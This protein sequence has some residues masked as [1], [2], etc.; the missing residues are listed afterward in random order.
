MNFFRKVGILCILMTS[1]G[2]L[3]LSLN[4]SAQVF[5]VEQIN[6]INCRQIP[7][8]GNIHQAV[9]S[10]NILILTNL[11]NEIYSLNLDE[12]KIYKITET[13]NE[14]ASNLIVLNS[15]IFFISKKESN[16][17]ITS[18][19]KDIGIIK[20]EPI[21]TVGSNENLR[22]HYS[23]LLNNNDN[24]LNVISDKKVFSINP[25]TLKISTKN[26]EESEHTFENQN[27]VFK[28]YLEKVVWKFKTGGKITSITKENENTIITSL[29]NF[30]YSLSVNG[31]INWKRRFSGRLIN[32]PLL[33][34]NYLLLDVLGDDRLFII[35]SSNGNVISTIYSKTPKPISLQKDMVILSSNNSLHIYKRNS[36]N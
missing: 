19:N 1:A 26:K 27:S 31:K 20:Y 18:I 35:D 22:S 16:Y 9:A 2:V 30:L 28:T 21:Q 29:D 6:F 23:I 25:N 14:I 36:C 33:L 12:E 4:I 34:E 11:K 17:F 24:F 13:A 15:E 32:K 8:E 5:K 10:D 3:F 7:F